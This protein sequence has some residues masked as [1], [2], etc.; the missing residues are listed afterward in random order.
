MS[1]YTIG[2]IATGSLIGLAVA[3]LLYMLGGRR[4]KAIRRFGGS[5]VIAL[6][7]N[8]A[9]F[10]MGIYSF[11]Y[12]LIYPLKIGEFSMGYGGHSLPRQVQRGL[13]VA[14]SALCG[15]IFCLTMGGMAWIVLA[16]QVIVG[17]ITI[18][19]A[20]KNPIWAAAEEVL[21]CVLNN[22]VLIFYPFLVTM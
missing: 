15:L 5:F 11:W 17:A 2:Y 4:H 9:S 18:L 6:T 16:I 20:F 21:V 22:G 7:V 3:C 12:L 1:E 13:I 14:T 19:F 10:F 8:L